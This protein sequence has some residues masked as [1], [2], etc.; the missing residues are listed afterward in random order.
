V[1]VSSWP[2]DLRDRIAGVV[3]E[4]TAASVISASRRLAATVPG[5][6]AC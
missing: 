1:I 2:L 6:S 3:A 5:L 4:I